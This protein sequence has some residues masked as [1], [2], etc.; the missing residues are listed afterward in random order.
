MRIQVRKFIHTMSILLYNLHCCYI[1][2]IEKACFTSVIGYLIDDVEVGQTTKD[3]TYRS[4][5]L[6]TSRQDSVD[7]RYYYTEG[8]KKAVIWVGGIGGGWDTPAKWMYPQLCQKLVNNERISS[9]RIRYRYP[10]DLDESLTDVIAG[11]KSLEH[12]GIQSVGLVG[13]SFGGAVVIEAAA[14][15]PN[16]VMTVVTLSTQSYRAMEAVSKLRKGCSI[17][18]IHG[19]DDDVLWPSCSSSVYNKANILKKIILYEGAKHGLE[20]A[21]EQVH[22]VVFQWLIEHL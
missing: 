6:V 18:L 5:T 7:C 21:A 1:Y 16:I 8:A 14:A 17:L 19:T 11:I 22:Q 4:I 12:D 2:N 13:H 3:D 9:L 10:R 20:E 15:V